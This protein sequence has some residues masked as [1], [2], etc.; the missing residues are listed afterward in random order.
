MLYHEAFFRSRGELSQYE[1]DIQGVTEEKNTLKILDEQK[2]E[3]VNGLRAELAV[4]QSE[5]NKL[6]D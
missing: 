4:T 1:A 3:E 5:Q 6:N 2:E